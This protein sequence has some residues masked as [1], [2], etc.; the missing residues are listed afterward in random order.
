MERGQYRPRPIDVASMRL[1]KALEPLIERLARN[2]HDVWAAQRMREGWAYGQQR[3]DVLRT[4]PCLT[5]YDQLPAHEREVDERITRETILSI[6]AMGYD[7][8]ESGLTR[9][10]A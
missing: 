6:L 7:V 5:P 1:P 10:R 8:V 3:D 2:A 9:A 4:N